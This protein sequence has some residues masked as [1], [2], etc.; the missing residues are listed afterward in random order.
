[1]AGRNAVAANN[2][3]L[4]S[5]QLLPIMMHQ[6]EEERALVRSMS[7]LSTLTSALEVAV[8][9][10]ERREGRDP[11]GQ[12]TTSEVLPRLEEDAR[13][14]EGRLIALRTSLIAAERESGNRVAVVRQLNDLLLVAGIG[15][16]LYGMH[17]RLMS[18]Y[19]A[20]TE[21]LVERSRLIHV[22][23][24]TLADCEDNACEEMLTF[25]HGAEAFLE[26]LRSEIKLLS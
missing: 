4:S 21:E 3:S 7:L 25:V 8:A 13:E 11:S 23:C 1:M 17:Q 15:R 2:D 6:P 14:L 12:Q 9:M 26:A 24:T 19:P 16:G 20:V 18:L 22:A 5:Q 10:R